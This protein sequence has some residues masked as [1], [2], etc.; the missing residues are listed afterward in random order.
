MEN[1]D[2]N[3][4]SGR[5]EALAS[6]VIDLVD[7]LDAVH[8]LDSQALSKRARNLSVGLSF[9]AP[10]LEATKRVLVELADSIDRARNQR[11]SQGH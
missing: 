4:L 10:H 6:L 1:Q 2:F 9:D 5:L 11:P 7:Q 3:E 8:G